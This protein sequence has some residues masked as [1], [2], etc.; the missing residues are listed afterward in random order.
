MTDRSDSPAR[1]L[2]RAELHILL[3]LAG[4]DRHGLGVAAEI[5]RATDGELEIGPGTL[6]RT[7][8]QLVE[9]GWIREVEAPRG[10]EDPRRRFYRITP[11]GRACATAEAERLERLVRLARDRRLLPRRS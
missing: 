3:A 7:L 4:E 2:T 1:S 11:S 9:E 5:E 8:K 10:E 6:Y